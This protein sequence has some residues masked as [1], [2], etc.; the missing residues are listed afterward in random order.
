V[1]RDN[2][3]GVT[4][5]FEGAPQ[6]RDRVV[7]RAAHSLEPFVGGKRS[8]AAES[9]L[10]LVGDEARVLVHVA[11]RVI[12]EHEIGVLLGEHPRRHPVEVAV[13]ALALLEE[14]IEIDARRE[15]QPPGGQLLPIGLARPRADSLRQPVFKVLGVGTKA[16]G[17][18]DIEPEGAFEAID[19]ENL[20]PRTVA[21]WSFVAPALSLEVELEPLHLADVAPVGD[22]GEPHDRGVVSWLA[23]G[24]RIHQGEQH[25][26]CVG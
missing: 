18:T 11:A 17:A 6:R 7:D 21:P 1:V 10:E 2:D 3:D 24:C 4:I 25:L 15:V 14:G 19:V 9:P 26:D 16:V 8:A 23:V 13:E 12:G 20:A 22:V 5:G